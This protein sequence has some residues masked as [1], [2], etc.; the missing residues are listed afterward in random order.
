MDPSG[1]YVWNIGNNGKRHPRWV[2]SAPAAQRGAPRPVPSAP[3]APPWPL[4]TA[5]PPPPPPAPPLS[6]APPPPPPPAPVAPAAPVARQLGPASPADAWRHPLRV[7]CRQLKF[8]NSGNPEFRNSGKPV[9]DPTPICP[10][11]CTQGRILNADGNC[12]CPGNLEWVPA[13]NACSDPCPTPGPPR[14]PDGSCGC[15]GGKQWVP[16]LNA[17]SDP[18][19]TPGPPRNPDG[20]CGCPEGE[21]FSQDKKKCIPKC[22]LSIYD[23]FDGKCVPKCT[24]GKERDNKGDCVDFCKPGQ[25]RIDGICK[26]VGSLL[27]SLIS[28]CLWKQVG[29]TGNQSVTERL[30]RDLFKARPPKT[31]S[32][33]GDRSVIGLTLNQIV[34]DPEFK[35][36]RGEGPGFF[37]ALSP[38]GNIE[39]FF[40]DNQVYDRRIQELKDA[41]E[42]AMADKMKRIS[43][44]FNGVAKT[45]ELKVRLVAFF[46]DIAIIIYSL[47]FK[48]IDNGDS[49]K[50]KTSLTNVYHAFL[51][52]FISDIPELNKIAGG[53]DE[54]N[55]EKFIKYYNTGPKL[56]DDIKVYAKKR[57]ERMKVLVPP[58]PP[59]SKKGGKPKTIKRKHRY[60]RKLKKH[61]K[62]TRK[63][64]K[65]H[66]RKHK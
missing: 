11:P 5:P 40:G 6:T 13:L 44:F 17:C 26:N 7:P 1:N 2:K 31:G 62:K 55:I 53:D 29:S 59:P 58:L 19:P 51:K 21:E 50:Q 3:P 9:F 24:N 32:Y 14:N 36:H 12:K 27:S 22:D 47:Y 33:M 46:F 10:P 56:L 30:Y 16:A 63:H 66:T 38:G 57:I 8:R 39:S 52:P 28:T 34:A 65:K 25:V 49:E 15:P 54:P 45:S 42:T 20:S 61:N 41:K 43:D 35:Y 18:C 23:M 64:S 4:P 48:N 37:K 60:S